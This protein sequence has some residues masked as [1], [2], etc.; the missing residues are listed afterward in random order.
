M[1]RIS[2]S[3]DADG[4]RE[5]FLEKN[6]IVTKTQKERIVFQPRNFQRAML[7]VGG[8]ISWEGSESPDGQMKNLNMN[9]Q[10]DVFPH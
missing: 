5:Q 3:M 7:N 6:Y 1:D 9:H 2:D 8:A 4:T 10:W